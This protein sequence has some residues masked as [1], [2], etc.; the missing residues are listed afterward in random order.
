MLTV[1]SMCYELAL[2]VKLINDPVSVLLHTRR[3]DHDFVELGHLSEE[4]ATVWPD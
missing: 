4:L 1:E 2:R 3:E